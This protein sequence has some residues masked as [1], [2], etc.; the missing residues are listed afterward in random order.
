M[1]DMR[2]QMEEDEQLRVLMNSL[3]GS[4]LS[5]ADFA[6]AGVQ[7]GAGRAHRVMGPTLG[8]VLRWGEGGVLQR[9]GV[10]AGCC[11]SWPRLFRVSEHAPLPRP[12]ARTSPA[13]AAGGCVG[14]VRRRFSAAHV[15]SRHH[16]RCELA[17]GWCG[18]SWRQLTPGQQ[19]GVHA[20]RRFVVVVV[21]P[22]QHWQEPRGR[23]ENGIAPPAG[24]PPPLYCPP[25]LLCTAVLGAP[26][27][28]CLHP[29]HPAAVHQLWL[30]VQVGS[31]SQLLLRFCCATSFRCPALQPSCRLPDMTR[32]RPP[33]P[34]T[35]A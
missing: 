29:N 12:S 23:E 24:G 27:R 11:T 6:D 35:S 25:A 21:L 28:V 33:P 4:N 20:V 16:C 34:R 31:R 19:R 8:G 7:V 3:R 17:A 18:S 30:P 15:R 5:D 9:A 1:R 14:G 2:S 13:D 10:T 26:P 22:E 32:Q